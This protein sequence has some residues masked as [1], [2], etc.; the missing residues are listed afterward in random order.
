V[1]DHV[2]LSAV[3]V[4]PTLG[5]P[6]IDGADVFCGAAAAA[7]VARMPT[8]TNASITARASF[9]LLLMISTP[10]SEFDLSLT[11]RMPAVAFLTRAGRSIYGVFTRAFLA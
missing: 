3:W 10:F 2:P 1:F 11:T 9:S 5:V 7:A 4:E 6:L 8:A